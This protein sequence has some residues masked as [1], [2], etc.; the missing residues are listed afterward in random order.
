MSVNLIS[1]KDYTQ[2]KHAVIVAGSETK[3]NSLGLDKADAAAAQKFF[4]EKIDQLWQKITPDGSLSIVKLDTGKEAYK[5]LEAARRAGNTVNK[6]L[7]AKRISEASVFNATEQTAIAYAFVE[8][9]ALSNYEFLKYKTKEK[10]EKS[11]AKLQVDAR[12][13][14]KAELDVLSKMVTANFFARTLINEPLS[15]LTAVQLSK[16][17]QKAGRDYGF[18][19]QVLDKKKITQLKMGGLLSVNRGSQDPPTFTI[20]EY[21]NP[22]ARNKKPIVLV[23]KGVVYDTGGLSLKPTPNSMDMMKCDMSGAAA[24]AG[25]FAAVASLKLPVHIVGLIPATDNRPGENAYVPGDVIEMMSGMNVEMLNADA[26]GRMILADALHYA[27]RYNPELVFDFATLTGAAK[28]ATGGVASPYM[29]TASEEVKSKLINSA[30]NTYERLIEF[31]MWDEYGDMIKSDVADIKNVGGPE[32]GAITAGKFL[33]HFTD[34]PWMHFDIAGTAYLMAED[35]YRGKYGT[36]VGV[37]LIT[38]FLKNY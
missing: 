25:I 16:E 7:N 2:F 20:L 37:R 13:L 21:K 11:L 18:N 38:D 3:L 4:D 17:I 30:N 15:Y 5:V 28:A 19:V 8:G 35:S 23:G 10:K 34:Y 31:P 36:A 6:Y 14:S 26:E 1:C 9:I 32:A 29:G 33:E 22:K 24:V 27:K 12:S